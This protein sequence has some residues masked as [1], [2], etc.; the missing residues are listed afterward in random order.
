MPS[1]W[2]GFGLVLLEAMAQSVPVIA[3]RV[4][5]IPEIVVDGETGLLAEPRDVETLASHLSL[6][7]ND[8]PLRRHMGM[9]GQERLETRFSA[10]EMIRRTA[11]VYDRVMQK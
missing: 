7:L 8:T 6:L 11:E 1:L 9:V 4:S 10:D 5:A 3:S 2:E